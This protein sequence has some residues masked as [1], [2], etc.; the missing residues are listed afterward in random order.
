M[1]EKHPAQYIVKE[2][3]LWIQPFE[4][5]DQHNVDQIRE[6]V[7]SL[8]A[9]CDIQELIFD[10]SRVEFMDSSGIG[11]VLGRYRR[12]KLRG[13]FVRAVGI[14]K[15]VHRIFKYSGLYQI[16]ETEAG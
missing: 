15:A 13:G 9:E 12:M 3:S 11:M 2:R 16:I 1:K 4:D 5:L 6:R 10:L 7:D 8:V 14:G